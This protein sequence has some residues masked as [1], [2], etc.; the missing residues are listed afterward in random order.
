MASLN[1]DPTAVEPSVR[2]TIPPGTYEAVI[3]DSEMRPTRN[4]QGQ[5]INL[6]FEIVSGSAKGRR[7]W[8]WINFQHP[9]V[10]AQRIGQERLAKVCKSVGVMRLTDTAQLHNIP[11]YIKVAVDWRD[12]TKNVIKDCASKTAPSGAPPAPDPGSDPW[13]R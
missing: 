2:E 9:K 4:G 1:F 8:D 13:A 11:L 6:T 7:V 12:T 10:E 5:G 3:V